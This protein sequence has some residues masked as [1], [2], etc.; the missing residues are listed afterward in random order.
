MSRN[1]VFLVSNMYPSDAFPSYG[2]FVKKIE[3][4]LA[5]EQINFSLKSLIKGKKKGINLLL[6][7]LSFYVDVIYKGLFKSYDVIYIHFISH[8]A[9]PIY[10]ILLFK[11]KT[12]IIIN[13]HGSDV[14]Q[15]N[16]AF[17][18]FFSKRVMRKS[19]LIISPSHYFKS[20]IKSK[21]DLDSTKIIVSP[22]GGIDT[23]LFKPAIKKDEHFF[24]LGYIS[25]I[26][27]GKG[28]DIFIK[29]FSKLKKETTFPLK[30]IIGGDGGENLKLNSLVQ[31][32]NLDKNI[33][34]LGN[35]NPKDLTFWYNQM[36]LFIFPTK[37]EESLGLVGLEAL[38]CGI[39]VISSDSGG[40]ISYIKNGINGYLFDSENE[41]DLEEKI[42]LYLKSKSKNLFKSNAR[43]MALAY[44]EKV[45]T[46]KLAEEILKISK[47]DAK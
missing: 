16:S 43:K 22:S 10:F 27:K 39:P 12:K 15:L 5:E 46:T 6:S 34:I 37:L 35:V 45:V 2:I 32:L 24:T 9:I 38:S 33:Q 28:W 40:Q 21:F 29:A 19:Q 14:M 17:L 42:K 36:D 31:E 11:P 3:L 7:Y 8:C 4:Q 47:A 23:E 20:K 30:A 13:T 1:N 25:R 18:F 26:D 41:K 44:D